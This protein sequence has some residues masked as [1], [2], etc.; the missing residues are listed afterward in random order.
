MSQWV[1][2][3]EY[4]A[5]FSLSSLKEYYE[6]K[7]ASIPQLSLNVNLQLSRMDKIGRDMALYQSSNDDIVSLWKISSDSFVSA[8]VPPYSHLMTFVNNTMTR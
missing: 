2:T 7:F 6:V 5:S 4:S 3:I 1:A 8:P